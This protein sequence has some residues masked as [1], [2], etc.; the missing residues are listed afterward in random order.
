VSTNSGEP[1]LGNY[2]AVLAHRYALSLDVIRWYWASKIAKSSPAVSPQ[3]KPVPCHRSQS[4]GSIRRFNAF[5]VNGSLMGR[6]GAS[7]LAFCSY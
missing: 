5:R 2:P 6:N 4:T 3:P 1:Q 7:L